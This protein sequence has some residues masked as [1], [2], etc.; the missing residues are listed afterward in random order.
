MTF[1]VEAATNSTFGIR[2]LASIA[3][4][5]PRSVGYRIADFAAW[6][7]ASR[8]SSPLVRAVRGNQWVVLGEKPAPDGLE[9]A[10]RQTLRHSARSVFDLYHYI[11]NPEAVKPLVVMEPPLDELVK[12][13]EFADRGILVGGIH[14]RSFDLLVRWF[15]LQGVKPLVLTLPDPRGA[16]RLEYEMRKQIG[17]NLVPAT[18]AGLRLA[19]RHLERGGAVLTS[20]DFPVRRPRLHPRFFGRPSALPVHHIFL[21]MKARVPLVVMAPILEADGKFHIKTSNLIEVDSRDGSEGATLRNAETVFYTAEK[22]VRQAPQQ[23]SVP[24]AVWP[25]ALDLVPE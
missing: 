22:Y 13:P 24:H 19:V 25:S 17:M 2:L 18:V 14:T 11:G 12:R 20:M 9:R 10:V 3:G 8:R 1:D 4:R 15:C 6:R 5:L 16:R 23:W 7:M 21:A